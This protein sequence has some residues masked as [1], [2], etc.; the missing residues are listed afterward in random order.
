MRDSGLSRKR[1]SGRMLITS[2]LN[3]ERKTVDFEELQELRN[4]RQRSFEFEK[5]MSACINLAIRLNNL[6]FTA[7]FS[8]LHST[9]FCLLR[10]YRKW[11]DLKRSG[12]QKDSLL[13]I[14]EHGGAAS[15]SGFLTR[16]WHSTPFQST[17]SIG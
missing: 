7:E 1:R 6:T 5:Y 13:R 3:L 16:P 17:S 8:G 12:D 2:T 11:R 4:D 15:K 14:R 9:T 10:G